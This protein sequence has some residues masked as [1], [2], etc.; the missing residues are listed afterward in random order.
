MAT[1]LEMPRSNTGAFDQYP[2]FVAIKVRI[3]HSEMENINLLGQRSSN[4]LPLPA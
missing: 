1:P 3:I 2:Q 4:A